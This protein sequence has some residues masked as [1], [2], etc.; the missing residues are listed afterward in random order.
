MLDARA[1]LALAIVVWSSVIATVTAI[2]LVR[3]RE[4]KDVHV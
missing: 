1:A 4:R 3:R 2:V